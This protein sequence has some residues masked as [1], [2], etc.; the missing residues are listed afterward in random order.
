MSQSP[1]ALAFLS[2]YSP[3]IPHGNK[4]IIFSG[5]FN[6][7]VYDKIVDEIGYGLF[8]DG[9]FMLFSDENDNCNTCLQLWEFVLPKDG[10]TRKVIG[11]NAYGALLVIENADQ[12]GTAAAVGILDPLTVSY[13]KDEHCLF[14]N[15]LGHWLPE[16]KVLPSFTDNSVYHAMRTAAGISLAPDEMLAIKVPITLGGKMDPANFQIENIQAYYTTTASI[17]NQIQAK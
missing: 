8:H 5:M 13:W 16:R 2:V 10:A 15:L 17:Y 4:Q 6:T 11:R 12:G 9:F 1:L 7:M 3:G 14:T